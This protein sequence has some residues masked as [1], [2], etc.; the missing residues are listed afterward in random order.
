MTT[1]ETILFGVRIG[2]ACLALLAGLLT[3]PND[4]RDISFSVACLALV[5]AMVLA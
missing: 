2:V 4:W 5:A 1:A 3:V